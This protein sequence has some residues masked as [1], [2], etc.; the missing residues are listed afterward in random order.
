M[1]VELDRREP[2]AETGLYGSYSP[3][4]NGTVAE[5]H[6]GLMVRQLPSRTN[7]ERT[8]VVRIHTSGVMRMGQM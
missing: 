4:L 2:A 7:S 3:S 6:D 5:S 1:K 8:F